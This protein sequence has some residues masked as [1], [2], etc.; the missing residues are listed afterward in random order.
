MAAM[1]QIGSARAGGAGEPATSR[2]S[3]GVSGQR[4]CVIGAGPSGTA[5]LRAFA[6]ASAKGVEIPEVVCYEKQAELGGLWNYSWRTVRHSD[7]HL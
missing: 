5:Q 6:A 1:Q 2:A 3:V 4:V 7:K